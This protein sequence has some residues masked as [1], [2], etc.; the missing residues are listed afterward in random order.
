MKGV[1]WLKKYILIIYN[2][3]NSCKIFIF[4]TLSFFVKKNNIFNEKI[5][6][7]QNKSSRDK[8]R[9]HFDGVFAS[10]HAFVNLVICANRLKAL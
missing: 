9:S 8:E 3:L 5:K 4:I 10:S 1:F 2:H 7:L 6:L